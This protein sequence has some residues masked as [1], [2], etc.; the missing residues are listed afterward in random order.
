MQNASIAVAVLSAN[1][2]AVESSVDRL[3]YAV[4]SIVVVLAAVTADIL[5][6]KYLKKYRLLKGQ[7]TTTNY[8]ETGIGSIITSAPDGKMSLI[9]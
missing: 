7:R 1:I 4:G 5:L 3:I 8:M 9:K 6:T 2:N